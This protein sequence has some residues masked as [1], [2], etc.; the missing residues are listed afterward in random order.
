MK[1]MKDR[2]RAGR[3]KDLIEQEV[4][5][6]AIE[7]TDWY[8]QNRNKDMVSGANSDEHQAWYK[9]DDIYKA[10]KEVPSAEITHD[11]VMQYCNSRLLVLATVESIK[12]QYR[13]GFEDGKASADRPQ[14]WIP[15]S[16]RLPKGTDRIS[17]CEMVLM[18]LSVGDVACGWI[19]GDTA[20]VLIN[21]PVYDQIVIADKKDVLAWMPLPEPWKETDGE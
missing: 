16:E 7:G 8:H 4:A 6:D 18:T 19:N 17:E 21:T 3:M 1:T 5:I 13:I 14:G 12:H 9:A 2:Q 11:D 20:Y 15:C 10:L